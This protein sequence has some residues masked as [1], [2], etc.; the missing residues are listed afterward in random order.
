MPDCHSEGK[1]HRVRGIA[2]APNLGVPEKQHSCPQQPI[3][4]K[5]T[6]VHSCP[7]PQQPTAHSSPELPAAAHSPTAPQQPT[8]HS[9]PQLPPAHNCLQPTV[10]HSCS[11]SQLPTAAH[12]PQQP[13][14]HS[15]P[16]LPIVAHSC[17]QLPPAHSCPRPTAAHNCHGV[18]AGQLSS[19]LP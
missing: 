16:Q 1:Y 14:A 2:E 9:S 6:V 12:S 15:C 10:A 3:A 8:T 19:A 11:C 5:A 7:S 4:A 13:T 18:D 17:P